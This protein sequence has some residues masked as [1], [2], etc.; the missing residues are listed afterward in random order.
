MQLFRTDATIKSLKP[1]LQYFKNIFFPR[2]HKKLPSKVDHN[3]PNFFFNTANQPK[4]SPNLNFCFIKNAHSGT[5]H[6]VASSNTSPLEA[7]AFGYMVCKITF[8]FSF[9]CIKGLCLF[10]FMKFLRVY[11][12]VRLLYS[13][14]AYSISVP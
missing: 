7:Y 5:Y 8:L 2:K 14:L 6:K 1:W 10:C 13:L 4:T 3:R 11:I 9:C 12:N